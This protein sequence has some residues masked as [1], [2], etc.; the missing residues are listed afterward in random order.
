M[1]KGYHKTKDG[2]DVLEL[3]RS[4]RG[5]ERIRAERFVEANGTDWNG[6]DWK[7]KREEAERRDRGKMEKEEKNG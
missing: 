3:R 2:M 1:K 4:T 5:A 7:M 6:T